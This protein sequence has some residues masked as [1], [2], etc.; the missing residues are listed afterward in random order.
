MRKSILFVFLLLLLITSCKHQ[1]D[2]ETAK[3]EL[4]KTDRDFSQMSMEKGRNAAFLFYAADE[5]IMMRDGQVPLFGIKELDKSLEGVRDKQIRLQWIPL[6]A[7]VSGNLGYT[8]GKWE[9]RITG[10]D[11]VQYGTYVT[12]WKKQDNGRWQYVLDAGNNTP[13][14]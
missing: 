9:L 5:V 14:P 1:E 13:R 2:R 10:K 3:K 8:F 12:V 4:F 7:D 11:T 6:K